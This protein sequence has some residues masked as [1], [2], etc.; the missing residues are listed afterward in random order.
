MVVTDP[1]WIARSYV[2]TTTKSTAY[3]LVADGNLH[4]L[5]TVLN[6]VKLVD[7][8]SGLQSI[9]VVETIMVMHPNYIEIKHDEMNLEGRNVLSDDLEASHRTTD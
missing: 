8:A 9:I 4:I 7:T 5:S 2:T 1:S 6:P 3:S